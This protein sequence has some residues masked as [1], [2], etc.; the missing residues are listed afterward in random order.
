MRTIRRRTT[1]PSRPSSIGKWRSTRIPTVRRAR[2]RSD[3]GVRLGPSPEN[4]IWQINCRAVSMNRAHMP[5]AHDAP[6]R[7]SIGVDARAWQLKRLAQHTH[8][9]HT[10][11]VCRRDKMRSKCVRQTCTHEADQENAPL[12]MR[13]SVRSRA[14]D[15]YAVSGTKSLYVIYQAIISRRE[16]GRNSSTPVYSRRWAYS[17]VGTRQQRTFALEHAHVESGRLQ[18]TQLGVASCACAASALGKKTLASTTRRSRCV[19]D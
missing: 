13:T 7:S 8:F 15:A 3:S 10:S 5:Q 19:S 18:C 11:Q 2:R 9:Q 6:L 17:R 14:L 16:P 1:T 4:E 12:G